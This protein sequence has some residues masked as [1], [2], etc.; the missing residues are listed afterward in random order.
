MSKVIV[1][2]YGEGFY[3]LENDEMITILETSSQVKDA[4]KKNF[5][6]NSF[7]HKIQPQTIEGLD[8]RGIIKT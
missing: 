8:D 6:W 5:I 7:N 3:I 2:F 4:F 1:I